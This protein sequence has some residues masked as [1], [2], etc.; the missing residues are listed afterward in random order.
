MRSIS[1]RALVALVAVLALSAMA[2][3]T[4]SAALPEFSGSYV[5]GDTFGVK[6]GGITITQEDNLT[7]TCS[8]GSGRGS[9]TG[10][11]TLEAKLVLKGCENRVGQKFTSPGLLPGEI[12]TRE[13]K[14]VL[15]YTSK[16]NKEVGIVFNA[17][18]GTFATFNAGSYKCE[19]AGGVI[20]PVTTL[21]KKYESFALEL[22]M[23]GDHQA[24]TQYE[25]EAGKMITQ[26]PYVSFGEGL[27]WGTMTGKVELKS[28]E[29]SIEVKA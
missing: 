10:P 6:T 19:I 7:M 16:A 8:S 4:A 23:L 22:S 18:G 11:K 2:A 27:Y 1:K 3:A 13:L 12:E 17:A 24:I 5:S 15:A 25:N 29:S 14:S 28:F 26:I 9:I 21:N 20:A